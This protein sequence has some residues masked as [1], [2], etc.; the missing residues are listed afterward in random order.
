[1]SLDTI[2]GAGEHLTWWQEC[3]RAILIF[4]Y[5]LVLVLVRVAGRRLF[6]KWSALDI[7]VSIIIGSNLSRALTGNAPL[8]GTLAATTLLVGLHWILAQAAAR[9]PRL[10]RVLEGHGIRLAIEGEADRAAFLREAVS[11]KD[12]HEALR[13]SGVEDVTQTRLVTLEPSGTITVLKA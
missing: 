5:G 8:W 12:L 2:F 7:I 13:Q 4:A 11:E 6:G 9:S 10:S 1:M 3:A